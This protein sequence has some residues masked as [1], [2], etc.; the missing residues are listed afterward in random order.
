M[1]QAS[2]VLHLDQ[3]LSIDEAID[4]YP[5]DI[6]APVARRSSG[7]A[8]SAL[9]VAAAFVLSRVLGLA[10]EIILARQ[11]GTGPEMDAYVSAFKIPDMLFL[12]VM[13]GAFGAAF[14]P[15][16]GEYLANDDQYRAWRLASSVLTW[17]GVGVVVLSGL[18]FVLARPL[19]HVVAPGFD[20]YTE[21]MAVQLMRILLLSPVFLGLGIAAK[22]ILE[23]HNQFTLP[24]IA[25]LVYNI[26]IIIGAVF[27]VP[28]YGIYAV[29]WAV[30]IG[31]LGHFLVQVPGLVR[32]GMRF[33]PTLDRHVD[34]LGEVARLLGPRV[35]GLAVFQINF[36]AVTA[37]AST[38]GSESVSAINYAWQLL[39]LPHGVLALSISTVIFPTLAALYSKGEKEQFRSTLDRTLRPLLFLSIPSSI[40]LLLLRKPIV[41]VIFQS[42]DFDAESTMLVIA[43]LA[44]FAIGLLG[45]AL[46]EILTRVFYATRD[47]RTPVITGILTVVLNL[48]LCVLF[49]ESLGYKGLALALSVTTG[50]EAIILLLFLRGRIGHIV[51]ANFGGWLLKVVGAS[52]ALTVVIMVTE[53][54][55]EDALQGEWPSDFRLCPVRIRDGRLSLRVHDLCLDPSHPGIATGCQQGRQPTPQPVAARLRATG[56]GLTSRAAVRLSDWLY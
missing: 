16:F 5:L 3:P 27:F 34:G 40:G 23:A 32:A 6:S 22:G 38:T 47:T 24:A 18:C 52:A 49:M 17:A 10:R 33:R 11:F 37:F 15:V 14:I 48:L 29:G 25:P 7:L 35:I 45:Y 20:Q 55:L 28:E 13:A 2:Q 12:I 44:Y 30:I 9:I 4:E 8:K 39:M 19:M 46:T 53:P 21:D 36:I 51:E 42:G 31:A 26:A 50:A 54:W 41:Q 1:S 43:P 56:I